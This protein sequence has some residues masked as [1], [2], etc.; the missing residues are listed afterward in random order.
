[1][2]KRQP[3]RIFIFL[4]CVLAC[5]DAQEQGNPRPEPGAAPAVDSGPTGDNLPLSAVDQPSLEPNASNRSLVNSGLEVSQGM[6][7]NAK[8]EPGA[9]DLTGVTRVLGTISLQK[10]WRRESLNI[11]YL[12]G[13]SFSSSAVV[14]AT[15][16]HLVGAVQR[17]IW[18]SGQIALRDSFS[19]LPEG[20]FGSGAFGGSGGL[21]GIAGMDTGM[22]GGLGGLGGLGGTSILSSGQFGSLGQEPRIT[23]NATMDVVQE[24]TPR[25]SLTLAGSYGLLHFVNDVPNSINSRQLSGQAG[26]NY[27]LNRADQIG[28]V[29]GF[30]DFHY[31][32]LAGTALRSHVANVLYG[33]R[34]SE[35]MDLIIGG[36]PQATRIEDPI[37]G[38]RWTIS[39]TGQAS[40]RYRFPR[41]S[42]ALGYRRF[43]TSGSGIVP[44]AISDVV[45]FTVSKPVGRKWST[46]VD[47]GYARNSSLLPASSS[48]QSQQYSYWYAGAGLRRQLGRYFGLFSG[49]QYNQQLFDSSFCGTGSACA[50]S[51]G[52]H[53][54]AVGIDWHPSPIRLD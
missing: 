17:F 23:N 35:R 48:L 13:G 32:E 38:S 54:A 9:S 46:T 24:L 8:S 10:Q 20:S 31:P 11:G 16:E 7:S 29:Y 49:Y 21:I 34:I 18:R 42:L 6:D 51:T 47:T 37:S 50:S 5:A 3:L 30:Q 1:M 52:R 4:V 19:Y 43:N 45:T 14:G 22:G 15:Q 26:Y 44:G 28:I 2:E 33:R 39:G 25:S 40:L 36:G 27:Q 53:S 41:S 12:G